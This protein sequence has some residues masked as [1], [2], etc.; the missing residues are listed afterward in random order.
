MPE[1]CTA[2]WRECKTNCNAK[3]SGL[4]LLSA[5]ALWGLRGHFAQGAGGETTTTS[6][7]E[8]TMPRGAGVTSKGKLQ[9]L[10]GALWWLLLSPLQKTDTQRKPGN[11]D[12][13]Q[14]CAW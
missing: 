10:V 2:V 5:T 7:A 4:L 13:M 1:A 9:S 8:H 12:L 3:G 6:R 14:N 11:A